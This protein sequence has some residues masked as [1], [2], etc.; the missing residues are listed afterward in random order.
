MALARI[1][2]RYP[3]Q[4][5]ALSDELQERGYRVEVLSPEQTPASPA[6]LEI[7]LEDCEP[8]D[9]LRRAE[10]LA[11]QLRAD[12]AVA[13]GALPVFNPQQE[14]DSALTAATPELIAGTIETAIQ[15]AALENEPSNCEPPE[16]ESPAHEAGHARAV[17]AALGGFAAAV[18]EF[19]SSARAGFHDCLEIAFFCIQVSSH[20]GVGLIAQPSIVVHARVAMDGGYLGYLRGHRLRG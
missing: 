12:I 6:H 16:V 14:P 3:Q 7:Q 10:E 5:T 20:A 19:L 18:R 2:T 9:I 13:P 15:P 1:F 8:A 4:A 17:G 11:S